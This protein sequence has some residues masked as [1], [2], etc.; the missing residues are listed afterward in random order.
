VLLLVTDG[1]G[2]QVAAA[3]LFVA[4][5]ATD[6]LDGYLARRWD[7]RTRTGAWLDPLAD[8]VFVLATVITLSALGRF[9]WWATAIVFVREASISILRVILGLRGKSLPASRGAKAKTLTQ[10]LAITLY[11]LPLGSWADGLRLGVL[12]VALAL[13][14]VTGL[15]YGA[16]AAGWLRTNPR[17][18]GEVAGRS[19]P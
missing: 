1:D 6:G 16:E 9:P 10:V 15:Q 3:A 18:A 8:K 5:A 2:A 14:V 7:N 11:V 4:G 19:G 17:A 13:T 12:V